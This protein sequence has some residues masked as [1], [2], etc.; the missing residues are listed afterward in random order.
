[1]SNI[2]NFADTFPAATGAVP[3]YPLT[4][5]R[6]SDARILE[7]ANRL[8]A[9]L[10]DK[11]APSSRSS[12]SPR[13]DGVVAT[14]VFE[15]HADELAAWS[16]RAGGAPR[17]SW[18][19]IGV[20]T[21]DN[22]HAEDVFDALTGAGIPVEI[23]GLSGLLRLPEVAEIVATLHLLHD[24]TAN[25]SLLTLLTGP[26]WAIGPRD[27]RLL[28]RRADEIAGRQGRGRRRS[29]ST[30]HLLEIADGIDPA[31][32]PSLDDA[33]AD[34]GDAPYS[35]EA[36]ERFALLAGELRMLRT[37]VG[38]PLLDIVRRIIDTTGTD[39]EL[40]SAVSP[41][42]A[43]RRDNL[44]LF[45]KAVAEFQ[46]VD[47]DVTLPAL[48]AYLTAEDDQGNGLD[49]ATPTEAD[50]VKLLTVHRSKGL[51][52]QSVFLVGV[53]ETRFPSNRSR[54]LWTSSPPI[55]PAPLRGDAPDLPQ[56]Q[57]CD[58]AALDAYRADTRAHDR[59]GAAPGVR[60][61][62]PRRPPSLGLLL[63]LEPAGNAVRPVGLP[64]R[65]RD[66]LAR[67][68]SRSAWP[69]SRRRA[70]PTRTPPSTRPGRG[71]QP[72]PAGRRR[73]GS[74]PPRRCG[75]PTPTLRTTSST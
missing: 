62:H 2:L 1:M 34:P 33:L 10:Y 15:T 18:A 46:A 63:L 36:L 23:V 40:A 64:E 73:C 27:L 22:A 48:L 25:A 75:P 35:A 39:V 49:V 14:G 19:K 29:P 28:S 38:E 53:C 65:L 54:T 59:G 42:A 67:G 7:V 12:P 5:N 69:T 56:L 47:G 13:R 58:K 24:V 72:G 50:S 61:V 74:R 6:R 26:R 17:G 41:A 52:W 55:L 43:A 16:R 45:V 66:Q 4:V 3:T 37:H 30:D 70:P 60:R 68:A 9:P 8:A 31:E 20:L 51:E 21:R 44:D 71:R 11:Y 32:I 57:G